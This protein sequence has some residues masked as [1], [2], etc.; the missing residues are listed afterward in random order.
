M[1]KDTTEWQ[2]NFHLPCWHTLLQHQMM[3][4]SKAS[5]ELEWA[6]TN[7]TICELIDL[8]K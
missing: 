5:S 2:T 1:F 4:E 8:L 7:K 6:K 3:E